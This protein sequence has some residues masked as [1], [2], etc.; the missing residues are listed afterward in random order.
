M[1]AR[2]QSRQYSFAFG[3]FSLDLNTRIIPLDYPPEHHWYQCSRAGGSLAHDF[4]RQDQTLVA[5]F[6]SA[7][8][9]TIKFSE[10]R[11][12]I[13]MC[14]NCSSQPAMP[15]H[16]L[17]CLGL[18]KQDLADVPLLM[19]DFLKVYDVMDLV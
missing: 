19:L 12:R 11:K 17:E 14:M 6:R 4:T 5:H 8:I 18:S 9:K 7:H 3:R 15:A 13:E 10:R 1:L 2:Y 16:I